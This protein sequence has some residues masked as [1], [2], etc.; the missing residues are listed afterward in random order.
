MAQ[1]AFRCLP[2]LGVTLMPRF[3]RFAS[4]CT[5]VVVSALSLNLLATTA[6]AGEL[7]GFAWHSGIASV[8][9]TT[10]LP[11]SAPNNDNVAG[12]SPNDVFI[13]Q[14]NYVGIGPVDLVFTVSDTGGVTEYQFREGVFNNT[15]VDWGAYHIELGFGHGAGFVASG[16]G[17][18][19]DFD[20][21]DYDSPL[22]FNPGP[23]FFPS[24]LASEDDIYAS[25]GVMPWLTFAG[26]FKF[27]VD[28]P[29]GITEFTIRQSPV[30]VPE[31]SAV[32][33]AVLGLV[34]LVGWGRR[35]RGLAG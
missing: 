3:N 22:D 20:A 14:K 29:D 30:P 26:Y 25:G 24:V 9:A 5:L 28:V 16:S 10:I 15:G 7:T 8:A 27:A 34:G 11:P 18:G 1:A 31:P 23:G 4:F 12:P 19:L 6:R 32:M 17:D 21:P 2:I 35:R 33:L 13:T